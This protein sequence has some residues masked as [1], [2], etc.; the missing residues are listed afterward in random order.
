[1]LLFNRVWGWQCLSLAAI[2]YVQFWRRQSQRNW[3]RNKKIETKQIHK[4]KDGPARTQFWF[5]T[6][7]DIMS[8]TKSLAQT[9]WPMYC[10]TDSSYHHH[11]N[12]IS[13]CGS[14]DRLFFSQIDVKLWLVSTQKVGSVLDYLIHHV[15]SGTL[16][17][18]YLTGTYSLLFEPLKPYQ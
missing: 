13:G 3:L 6:Q 12:I 2:R 4:G 18:G 9:T 5:S 1:M 7:T 10:K 15:S 17:I 8:S 16:P 11:G 14:V